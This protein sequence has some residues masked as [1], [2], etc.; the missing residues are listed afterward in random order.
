MTGLQPSIAHERLHFVREIEETQR[1]RDVHA[2]LPHPSGR[3]SCVSSKR[4]IRFRY[5]SA[6]ST[7][8][9]LKSLAWCVGILV[10]LAPLAVWRSQR[11]GIR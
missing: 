11:T 5:A 7:A 9:V 10:T 4:S 6:S 8:P 3:L 2:T 1:V